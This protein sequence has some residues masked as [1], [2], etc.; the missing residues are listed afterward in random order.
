MDLGFGNS[1]RARRGAMLGGIAPVADLD[2]AHHVVIADP[3]ALKSGARPS[4]QDAALGVGA[5]KMQMCFTTKLR[6]PRPASLTAT[7]IPV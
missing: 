4:I 3:P 1:I 7:I 5:S 2:L 6:L